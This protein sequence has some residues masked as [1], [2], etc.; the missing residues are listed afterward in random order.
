LAAGPFCLRH[1]L[2]YTPLSDERTEVVVA[3]KITH[4]TRG[5]ARL[6]I[7]HEAESYYIEMSRDAGQ[8]EYRELDT[9]LRHEGLE[10]LD[11]DEDQQATTL[12]ADG[13]VRV[14]CA[15]VGGGA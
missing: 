6:V 7:D 1:A 11:D 4:T 9:L 12:L 8:L 2:T 13:S 15:L 14:W 10:A 5:L 3:E